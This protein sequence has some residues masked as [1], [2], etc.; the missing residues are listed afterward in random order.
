MELDTS[1]LLSFTSAA[2]QVWAALMVFQVLLA[3][4]TKTQATHELRELWIRSHQYW[5]P[6]IE[7]LLEEKSHLD[8]NLLHRV[9]T[10]VDAFVEFMKHVKS[11]QLAKVLGSKTMEAKLLPLAISVERISTV[12]PNLIE[13]SYLGL[14][15]I[16]LNLI[17]LGFVEILGHNHIMT[18]SI[19]AVVV[20]ANAICLLRF[21]FQIHK[22]FRY[23]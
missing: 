16:S 10:D 22:T 4:D 2:A 11:D 3:R 21:T 15:G 19:L 23:S 20:M 1:T 12:K 18:D 5:A 6:L 13:A 8:E 14:T 17:I 7:K 9:D